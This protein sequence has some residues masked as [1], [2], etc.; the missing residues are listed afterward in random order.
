MKRTS[1]RVWVVSEL[2]YPE[3]TSTGYLLTCTAEGIARRFP[4][5]VLCSQP[6]YA[7]RGQ[8]SPV[9]EERNGVQI[10]RCWGTTFDKDRILL[11]LINMMTITVSIFF[12]ALVR[13]R[14]GD[15]VFVVTNPPALPFAVNLACWLRRAKCVLIIHDVYPEVLIATGIATSTAPPIRLIRWLTGLLYRR[16]ERI[17]VLGRDM[18]ELVRQKL[19]KGDERTVI[20]PN[21]ADLDLVEPR[22]RSANTLLKEQGLLDKFVIQYAGNMGR[23]HGLEHLIAV[24]QRLQNSHPEVHFLLIGSGAKKRWVEQTA[25]SLRLPNL[26][27][28]GNRPRSDQINFLNACDI[29]LISFIP[30]MAGVS[31]PSRMYN[32]M[33]AGKP[34]IA[35][36]DKH[37]ELAQVVTEED[38]GWVIEPGDEAA[39]ERTIIEAASQPDLLRDMGN[40]ARL[41]AE[42]KYS[43]DRANEA[44][45]DIVEKLCSSLS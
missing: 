1:S 27:L 20:I 4:V 36:A 15:C 30:G 11:R 21:W 33:A 37:S 28:L 3:E 31:V 18:R 5:S 39:L 23:T 43:L 29:A 45:L 44:Y 6:T 38:I 16:S 9:Y 22:P 19:P 42:T 35:M 24:A 32:I 14:R 7:A 8:R 10:Y 17:V 40:R 13:F 2:Y 25:A 41:A 12:S 26:T 34:I